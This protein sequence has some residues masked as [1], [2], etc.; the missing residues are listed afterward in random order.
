MYPRSRTGRL[1]PS[2]RAVYNHPVQVD[3]AAYAFDLSR[4]PETGRVNLG[5]I[6]W[7]M[8]L[9]RPATLQGGFYFAY[10]TFEPEEARA[11]Y[12]VEVTVED[13]DG[14]KVAGGVLGSIAPGLN[15]F[16]AHGYLEIGTQL[17]MPVATTGIYMIHLLLNGELAHTTRVQFRITE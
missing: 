13:P 4:H 5:E 10:L 17:E 14:R 6:I 8:A 7:S 1:R 3:I 12:E 2:T 16:D 15:P 9:P 11:I